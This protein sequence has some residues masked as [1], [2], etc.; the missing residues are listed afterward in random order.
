MNA[1][2]G[3]TLPGSLEAFARALALPLYHGLSEDDQSYV[4]ER[5]K[6]AID[7]IN[8]KSVKPPPLA[9]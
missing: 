8:Y 4:V 3:D 6:A 7:S 5:L 1:E 2:G 9:V